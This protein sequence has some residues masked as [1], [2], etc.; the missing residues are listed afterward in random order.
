MAI[1]DKKALKTIKYGL[2]GAKKKFGINF[3]RFTFHGTQE[4][5]G[6]EQ[7]FFIELE[8]INPFLSPTQTV[9]GFTP[10]VKI[11]ENDLQYAL[12][13]TSSAQQLEIEE[14]ITP[15]YCVIR[16]GMLG[17][18]SKQLCYYFP[19]K[20]ATFQN[21]PF[22]IQIDNKFFTDKRTGGFISI[23]EEYKT[24]HP[25]CL[26]DSG[27]VK[28]DISYEIQKSFTEGYAK[29][30]N[31][32][33]PCGLKTEYAGRISFDG[34]DYIIDSQKNIG[35]MERYY[36]SSLPETWF[37]LSCVNMTSLISGKHLFNSSFATQGIF[38]D[39]LSF[40]GVFEE[41]NIIFGAHKPKKTHFIWSC[42]QMPEKDNPD[43]NLLHWSV[44][45]DNKNWVVDLDIF[46]KITE[47]FN[48]SV[49]C[50]SGSRKVLH[51]LEGATGYG[52]IKLYKRIGESLEQIEHAELSK[53]TCEFGQTEE[54]QY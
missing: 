44:S 36:G 20:N 39:K 25:E 26:C 6:A 27:Y 50:P 7:M 30:N 15:S 14:K 35:Y 11:S 37:H 17:N 53:V 51:L 49:E 24:A 48:R 16:V 43:S 9:L 52:E 54:G 41:L 45:F 3:W 13:G 5:T 8:M 28:W 21:K 4:G 12:A 46:C 2:T 19:I 1:I 40:V 29:D 34:T 38:D 18:N 22:S 10:H 33:F 47:L 23:S 32:W 31:N 42:V